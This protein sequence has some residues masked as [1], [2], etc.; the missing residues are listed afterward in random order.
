MA[1]YRIQN[2]TEQALTVRVFLGPAKRHACT[3]VI[4]PGG[5]L[6]AEGDYAIEEPALQ[7]LVRSGKLRIL[8]IEEPQP[9]AITVEVKVELPPPLP[10][11]VE[12]RPDE[13]DEIKTLND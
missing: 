1:K 3:S 8:P 11:P 6:F 13:D 12:D 9:A 4:G 5:D 10:M 7:S 2:L